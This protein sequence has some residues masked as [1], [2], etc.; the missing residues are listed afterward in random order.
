MPL[1][2]SI[3]VSE[4]THVLIWKVT[5]SEEDLMSGL[6]LG[7]FSKKRLGL[8][9]SEA[10]RCSYLAVRQLLAIAQ[11]SDADL[12]YFE[13]GKPMLIDGV[14]ISITHSYDYAA[15]ILSEQPVGI[16]IEKQRAKINQ[17]APKFVSEKETEYLENTENK[18][19]KLTTIW[20]IKEAIYKLFNT[21][22][23]SFKNHIDVAPFEKD[24]PYTKVAVNYNAK[25]EFYD[26]DIIKFED[27]ICVYVTHS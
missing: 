10:H 8:M 21:P 6:S 18:I 22:G 13:T 26:V 20:C 9:K 27:F 24:A 7:E 17:I 5:E 4:V 3:A 23:L 2:K 15:I 1:Y 11:Y 12:T 19:E 25:V 16:D 14:E